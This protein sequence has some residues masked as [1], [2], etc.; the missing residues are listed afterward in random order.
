MGRIFVSWP[1][2]S[3]DD[4]ETGA[5][6]RAAGY[7]LVLEPK[8][9]ARSEDEL[10]HLMRDCCAAI[11]STDPFT[12]RAIEANPAL[13]VI[14]R[15][16]V[17]TDS[18]D[19]QAA[20]ERGIAICVTPGLNAETVADHTLALI[21]GLVRKVVTQDAGV[22]A[23]KWDRVGPAT[24]SELPGKTVGLVGAGSIAMAVA[25]RLAGFD[26]RLVFVDP[27]VPQIYGATKLESLEELLAVSDIVSLHAPLVPDTR[28]LLS[29]DRLR[30][31]KPEA[32]IVNTA[33]G[34]LIDQTALL[35]ALKERRLGGAAL[36]VFEE[37]PPDVQQLKDVPNLITSAHVGGISIESIR[38]MTASA[39]ASVLAVLSGELPATVINA[40]ALCKTR[41]H[42]TASRAPGEG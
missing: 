9:G 14:A 10:I 40:R 24:P 42:R 38:R 41:Q 23:G 8:L 21:L 11:V 15:V 32:F 37:E 34:A 17:G 26:V 36:D 39:T 30:L 4:A 35:V 22:K 19:Q 20:T 31:M 13:R 29:S 12:R 16:G 25:R 1:G 28:M 33:R 2:F 6:L 5:R 18:V 7:Q 3:A 27:H